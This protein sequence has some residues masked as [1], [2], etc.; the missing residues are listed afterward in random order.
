M[1]SH[2]M[3]IRKRQKDIEIPRNFAFENKMAQLLL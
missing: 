3:I 2:L 1:A